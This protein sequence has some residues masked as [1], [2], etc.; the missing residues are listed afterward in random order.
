MVCSSH[1][2]ISSPFHHASLRECSLTTI[3]SS[4]VAHCS[5]W[6]LLDFRHFLAIRSRALDHNAKAEAPNIE[7]R[8]SLT[9]PPAPHSFSPLTPFKPSANMLK[10]YVATPLASSLL[11]SLRWIF[12]DTVAAALPAPWASLPDQPLLV[13]L[14]NPSE[15]K[16]LPLSHSPLLRDGRAPRLTRRARSIRSLALLLTVRKTSPLCTL[17]LRQASSSSKNAKPDLKRS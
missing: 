9:S 12:A 4:S 6:M 7:L 15:N 16:L 5:R 8:S 14:S 11:K 10:T 17:E 3:N 2:D 13:L 1:C